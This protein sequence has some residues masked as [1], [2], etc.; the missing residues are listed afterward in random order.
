VVFQLELP[1]HWRIHNVFHAS[2][3]SP[4]TETDIHGPNYPKPPPD[5]IEGESEFK[6]EQIIGSR[7]TGKRKTLQY[8]VRWK[9]YSPAHDS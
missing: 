8:K 5:I 7:C 6:V 9:G 1:S 4:Y 2:L 3:L